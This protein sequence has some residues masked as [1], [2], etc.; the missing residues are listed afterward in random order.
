MKTCIN[1][2]L[3]MNRTEMYDP[4]LSNPFITGYHC[5]MCETSVSRT[6]YEVDRIPVYRIGLK[7]PYIIRG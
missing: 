4:E 5:E 7:L 3:E 1:C 2:G 6:E